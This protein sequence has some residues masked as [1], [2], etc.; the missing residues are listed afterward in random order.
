MRNYLYWLLPL[1]WM[2]INFH[3]SSQ[4]YE[5]QDIKPLLSN[6]IDLSFLEPYLNWIVFTR[7]GAHVTVFFLLMIFFYLAFKKS[8]DLSKRTIIVVSFLFTVTYAGIDELH[9][10]FTPNR[11][12]YVG[13]VLLDSFGAF[14][15][16]LFLVCCK[17]LKT[18]RN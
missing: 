16:G 9:Q 17:Q 11:T 10:G 13:D 4:P 12:P 3:S 7:K 1:G 6:T 8:T 5:E 15:A 2:R 18:K 14:I